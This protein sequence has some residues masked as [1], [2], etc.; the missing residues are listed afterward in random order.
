MQHSDD[1]ELEDK[2]P[3]SRV[4]PIVLAICLIAV[5]GIAVTAFVNGV[6]TD[7]PIEPQTS[8]STTTTASK[9][10]AQV[11]KPATDI[12]DDRTTTTTAPTASQTASTENTDL[13]VFPVSNRIL[14]HFSA[15]HVFS[16]T[17]GEWV[18]HNGVDF[19]AQADAAVKAVADGEVMEISED[20]LWGNTVTLSHKGTVITR[21]CG[22][23]TEKLQKGQKVS[24]GE[25]IGTVASVPAEVL[26]PTHLHL[27]MTVNGSYIDPLTVI[28][29]ET[30][31]VTAAKKTE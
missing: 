9:T 23:K 24:A 17:L 1:F 10:V 2:K 25:P 3:T 12:P 18:T 5:C 27:E 31:T 20:A 6:S 28:T 4:F 29:G 19:E 16:E 21:Y 26:M 8:A 13:F 14:N 22:V 15:T 11:V 7:E 30:I